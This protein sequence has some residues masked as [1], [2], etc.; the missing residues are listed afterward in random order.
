V[1][2]GLRNDYPRLTTKTRSRDDEA[3]KRGFSREREQRRR[4]GSSTAREEEEQQN[5]GR[6]NNNGSECATI[7]VW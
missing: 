2:P 6:R 4:K 7:V 5:D 1:I 3:T